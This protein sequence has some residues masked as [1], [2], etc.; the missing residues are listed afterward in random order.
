MM[1]SVAAA[2]AQTAF[3]RCLQ[4]MAVDVPEERRHLVGGN[5]AEAIEQAV[6]RTHAG[7][8]VIGSVSRSGLKRLLVGNTAEKLLYRLPC[9]MLIVKPDN[10]EC[11]VAEES[12]GARLIVTPACS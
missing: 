6:A 4:P 8:L 12:R 9:D 10:F 1:D 7:I 3:N 5:P 11:R 2:D